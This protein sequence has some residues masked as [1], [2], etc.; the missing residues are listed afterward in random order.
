M[1]QACLGANGGDGKMPAMKMTGS[2]RRFTAW[3]AS[4]AILMAALAPTISHAISAAGFDPSAIEICTSGGSKWAKQAD[5][6][7]AKTQPVRAAHVEHCPFCFT[8]AGANGLPSA[9]FSRIAS[10]LA[11]QQ[12]PQAV[13]SSFHPS[14]AWIVASSRAPPRIFS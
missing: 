1:E 13:P 11:V 5:G 2:M 10:P 14:F 12:R 6:R 9:G 8:H 3:I 7:L 4:L